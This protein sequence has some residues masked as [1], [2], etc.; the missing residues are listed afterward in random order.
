MTIQGILNAV[1]IGAYL[2]IIV[3]S[4]VLTVAVLLGLPIYLASRP[5][6]GRDRKE[7]WKLS[8]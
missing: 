6:I 4:M 3:T 5:I 2:G 8:L 1:A 7:Q